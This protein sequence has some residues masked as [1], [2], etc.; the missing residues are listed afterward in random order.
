VPVAL[1]LYVIRQAKDA[2][3]DFFRSVQR[4]HDHY[5][6]IW[7]ASPEG[8]VLSSLKTVKPDGTTS[9]PETTEA[10]TKAV[11]LAL[12]DGIKAFGHVQPRRVR[13]TNPLPFCGCGRRP[14]GSVML[15][16]T[17]RWMP[18]RGVEG[19]PND[20]AHKSAATFDSFTLTRAEWATLAPPK[21]GAGQEW[22]V[23]EA[24]ARKFCALLSTGDKVFR[25]PQEVTAVR[26]EG[27][28][29]A[30]DNGVAYLTFQGEIAG[31]HVGTASEGREGQPLSSEAKLIA[32][33]G[34][35]DTKAGCM[36]SVT[37]VF[38]GRFRNYPPYDN[39]AS[40]YGAVVEWTLS[41]KGPVV[42]SLTLEEF[43]KLHKEIR[44][45]KD[46]RWRTIPW[47]LSL[48]EAQRLSATEQKPIFLWAMAGNPLACV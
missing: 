5:Q 45:P 28:V 11:L 17:D 40:R 43:N 38:D 4:Q 41:A 23:P 35:Y 3:G 13:R 18:D 21:S 27:R 25:D 34:S 16:V 10:W 26:I 32:G 33:A 47:K 20:P 1:N 8:K 44:P 6:G 48:L 19:V 24:T 29:Q 14:D 2:A 37:L 39:P 36:L 46:E 31:K 42:G 30:V 9:V 22:T 15:A 7:I 12:D